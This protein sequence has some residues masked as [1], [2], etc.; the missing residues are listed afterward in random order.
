MTTETQTHNT[1]NELAAFLLDLG[2]EEVSPLTLRN[3]QADVANFAR[4]FAGSIGKPFAAV[5]VTPTDVRDYKAH[6]VTVE[7]RKPATVNR[8]LAAL[9]KFFTWAKGR[10]LISE[11][12]TDPVKGV[13]QDRRAPRSLEAREVNR[14]IREAERR[15]KKRDIALL[16]TLRHTG[17]RVSELCALRLGDVETGE[18]KGTLIVRRGK[19]AKHRELPLNADVRTAINQYLAVRPR[20]DDDHLFLSQKTKQGLS[21]QAVT[22][23]VARY[24]RLAGLEH[25][26]PHTL[27]HT[28]GKG[29]LDA[30]VDLVTVAALLGHTNLNTTAIYTQPSARDLA[31]AVEKLEWEHGGQ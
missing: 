5:E 6:L 3:Y 29:L 14:L 13:P 25:V 22:D 31:R 21:T 27:R 24:A 12:P 30:G 16:K 15:T 1:T 11:L 17:L 18:R 20:V 7:R 4:W 10:R 19:G 8:R 28:F 2:R 9:R 26:T 23:V